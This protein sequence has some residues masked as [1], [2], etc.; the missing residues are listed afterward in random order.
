MLVRARIIGQQ[1][2]F[3]AAGYK[4]CNDPSMHEKSRSLKAR[5]TY[6]SGGGGGRGHVPQE[7]FE[8]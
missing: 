7:N 3:V 4:P 1:V 8:N 2:R 6:R 5:A